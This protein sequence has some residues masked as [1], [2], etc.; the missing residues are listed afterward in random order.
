MGYFM[1]HPMSRP[2]GRPRKLDSDATE[3]PTETIWVTAHE[4]R[5]SLG[6]ISRQRWGRLYREH[7]IP[8]QEVDGF[9]RF[10]GEAVEALRELLGVG[11]GVDPRDTA[12]ATMHTELEELREWNRQLFKSE[13]EL[14]ALLREEN[15]DLRKLRGEEQKAHFGYITATQEALDSSAERQLIL[16]SERAKQARMA[17]ALDY[18]GPAV[19]KIADQAVAG[20]NKKDPRGEFAERF[21]RQLTDEQ[22]LDFAVLFKLNKED[23]E[24]LQA[25]RGKDGS[26]YPSDAIAKFSTPA[27][28][29]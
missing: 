29:T 14:V 2:P 20:L 11:E 28:P 16:E 1:L 6:N 26:D 27:E 9:T 4:A 23:Y 15:A 8:T 10:D 18:L 12:L 22:V 19:I 5:M 21:A 25:M 3:K 24:R 13:R 7:G 17:G